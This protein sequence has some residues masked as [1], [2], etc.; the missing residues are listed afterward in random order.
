MA[1][2]DLVPF[3][4]LSNADYDQLME[5]PETFLKIL[6]TR[7]DTP[8]AVL[9]QLACHES[10]N[11]RAAVARNKNTPPDVL[12]VLA[13]DNS[14]YVQEEI[15][16]NPSTPSIVLNRIAVN[17]ARSSDVYIGKIGAYAIGNPNIPLTSILRVLLDCCP[18]K[19]MLSVAMSSQFDKLI[20][21]ARELGNDQNKTDTT[22]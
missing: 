13:N 1:A 14:Y 10:D 9:A 21:C 17:K 3:E 11:I 8:A 4:N 18:E 20:Q 7:S 5:Q 15:A 22:V 16:C 2:N 19:V 12:S 6:A